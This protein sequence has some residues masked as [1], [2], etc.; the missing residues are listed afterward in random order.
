M[1]DNASPTGKGLVA[2]LD[3]SSAVP[4]IAL[5]ELHH[6]NANIV[7][8]YEEFETGPWNANTAAPKRSWGG[9]PDM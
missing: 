4:C 5:S 6:A 1:I 3:A 2:I 8:T 9:I 7:G